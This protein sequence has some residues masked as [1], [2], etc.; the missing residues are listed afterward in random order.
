[1]AVERECE[2]EKGVGGG[3]RERGEERGVEIS[4]ALHKFSWYCVGCILD[5]IIAFL[6]FSSFFLF[7]KKGLWL[8]WPAHRGNKHS[9]D[10]FQI[11]VVKMV[12]ERTHE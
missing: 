7:H 8:L 3:W 5:A 10:S 6:S 9:W 1:M 2:R 11:F 4:F 12:M